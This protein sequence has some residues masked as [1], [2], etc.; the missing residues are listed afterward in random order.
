[1]SD[2]TTR[3]T[4]QIHFLLEIDKLKQVFRRT[5]LL[6]GSRRE[7][8]A[9]HSWHQAI[10]VVLLQEYARPPVDVLHTMKMMLI[11]DVVEIDV[12]DTFIYDTEGQATK[13]ARER[14]AAER[15]FG[16]LP[17]DQAAEFRALWEEFEARET[18][19]ARY[20]RALDR[21]QPLLHNYFTEGRAWRE[22]EVKVDQ[23]L[24]VNQ[25]LLADGAPALEE[26]ATRLILDAVAKGYLAGG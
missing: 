21:L 1:M 14:L 10:M 5:Y 24:A 13:A 20:A 19:E 4:Q 7:N 17:A 26:Y 15:L 18:P 23:V 22:H 6:D 11:H 25:P 2:D 9:E 3:L 16:L 8:D 12:G